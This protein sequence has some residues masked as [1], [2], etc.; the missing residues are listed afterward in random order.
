[1]GIRTQLTHLPCHGSYAHSQ[2]GECFRAILREQRAMR[3]VFTKV[4]YL[5]LAGVTAILVFLLAVWLPA[6]PLASLFLADPSLSHSL[7]LSLVGGLLVSSITNAPLSSLG[8][9]ALAALLIGVNVSLLAFY[10]RTY[11][12]APAAGSVAGGIAGSLFA[13]I[14]FG[15]VSCGSV[16]FTTLFAAVGGTGLLATV[17]YLGTGVGIAGVVLLI[18]SAAFLARAINKPPV[19]PV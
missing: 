4:P 1:M 17:P 15:C 5:L 11:R 8:Y 12:A 13:L 16:F 9:T 14:G 18:L 10:L 6:L 2:V 19:C 3:K 7:A